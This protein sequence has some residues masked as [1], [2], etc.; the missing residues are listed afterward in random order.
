M[1]PSAH[2]Q[3]AQVAVKAMKLIGFDQAKVKAVLKKLLKVYENNWEYIEAENYRLL[4]DSIF[5]DQ[6]SMVGPEVN[7]TDAAASVARK[8]RRLGEMAES[9]KCVT[10]EDD[11]SLE[12]LWA[13]HAGVEKRLDDMAAAIERLATV[14][15]RDPPGI[16]TGDILVR[17]GRPVPPVVT[18]MG[19]GRGY[20]NRGRRRT[21][22]VSE[23]SETE[24]E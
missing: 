16:R 22:L 4:A 2:L 15:H 24:D 18:T 17:L 10:S 6:E 7:E 5:D 13:A 19:G 3:R 8:S 11:R 20:P 14:L 9:S 23:W 1:A 21:T 12:A